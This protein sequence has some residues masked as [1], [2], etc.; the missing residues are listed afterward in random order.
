[1][2]QLA[3]KLNRVEEELPSTSDV[4]K[5]GNIELKEFMENTARSTEDL[6]TQ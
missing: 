1:M 4:A 6:I 2:A 5:S 3:I